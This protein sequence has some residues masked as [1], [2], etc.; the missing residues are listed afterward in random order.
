MGLSNGAREVMIRIPKGGPAKYWQM[1]V[2]GGR[3][4]FWQLP[5]DIFLYSIDKQ[6]LRT[7]GDTYIVTAKTAVKA[8]HAIKVARLKY[9]GNWDP[10]PAGWRR[11]AALMHNTAG[12]DL[13]VQTVEPRSGKLAP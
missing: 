9:P 11:L 8:T 1:E 10:E 3:E 12:T 13:D 6:N 4:E 5:T 7:K 2:V